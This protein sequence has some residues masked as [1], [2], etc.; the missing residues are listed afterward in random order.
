MIRKLLEI[1]GIKI[2]PGEGSFYLFVDISGTGYSSEDFAMN[3]LK[4]K[5]VAVIPG[6]AFGLTGSGFIRVAF[7]VNTDSI[8][9]GTQRMKE[10]ILR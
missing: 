5:K 10:F 4:E 2:I 8:R 9:E 7:T 6:D 1:P 3:L